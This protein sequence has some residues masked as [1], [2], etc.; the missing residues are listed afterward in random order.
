M[1]PNT[2]MVECLKNNNLTIHTEWKQV[3]AMKHQQRILPVLPAFGT[4]S[5]SATSAADTVAALTCA[6]WGWEQDLQLAFTF[7]H[8]HSCC[9][10]CCC[11]S[12]CHRLPTLHGR[13]YQASPTLVGGRVQI[14]SNSKVT[15]VWGNL[16]KTQW[17]LLMLPSTLKN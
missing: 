11:S 4:A 6:V 17:L 5:S 9:C 2:T 14:H 10:C 15:M 13:K 8:F 1:P 16:L 12:C 7:R 3:S